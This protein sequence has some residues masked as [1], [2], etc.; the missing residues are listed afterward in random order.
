MQNRQ[1]GGEE[2]QLLLQALG[3]LAVGCQQQG[4]TLGSAGSFGNRQAQCGTGQVAPVLFPGAG[5][6]GRKA[7]YGYGRYRDGGLT[8]RTTWL[9]IVT[10]RAGCCQ[11]FVR[12]RLPAIAY[13]VI[14]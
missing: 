3:V 14:M 7:Q 8:G 6:Q 10:I 11:C 13:A 4:K 5:G 9:A 1:L 2:A 12:C